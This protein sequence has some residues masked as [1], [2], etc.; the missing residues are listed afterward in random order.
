VINVRCQ[1]GQET[2]VSQSKA[3]IV[4]LRTAIKVNPRLELELKGK[5]SQL[6]RQHSVDIL[7]STLASLVFAL[8][9]EVGFASRGPLPTPSLPPIGD[10]EDANSLK[11][12]LPT[13]SLPPPSA[14]EKNVLKGPLP[15]PSLPPV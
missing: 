13:P 7:P 2:T 6:L 4:A 11:G 9:E 15:T 5:I 10:R 3:D 1:A 8:E 12:P 14:D